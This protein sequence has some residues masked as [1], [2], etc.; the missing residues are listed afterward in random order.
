[1]CQEQDERLCYRCA[2]SPNTKVPNPERLETTDPWYCVN[3]KLAEQQPTAATLAPRPRCSLE[4]NEARRVRRANAGLA[5]LDRLVA[6]GELCQVVPH[7]VGLDLN[8]QTSEQDY[9]ILS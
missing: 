2:Q 8:L 6:D 4:R 5:V 7:H 1:M 3:R 9:R